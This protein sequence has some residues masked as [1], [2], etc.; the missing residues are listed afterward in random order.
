MTLYDYFNMTL[1]S[2]FFKKYFLKYAVAVIFI[3][4]ANNVW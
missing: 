2:S 3:V 4:L 1:K